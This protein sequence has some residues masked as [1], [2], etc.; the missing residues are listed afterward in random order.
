MNINKK[1]LDTDKYLRHVTDVDPSLIGEHL[2]P[3]YNHD[4]FGEDSDYYVFVTSFGTYSKALYF[5]RSKGVFLLTED[6]KSTLVI[7]KRYE[8]FLDSFNRKIYMYFLLNN[9]FRKT[10]SKEGIFVGEYVSK[11]KVPIIPD[12]VLSMDIDMVLNDDELGIAPRVFVCRDMDYYKKLRKRID[13]IKEY[14]DKINYIE[15][16]DYQYDNKTN[17][18]KVLK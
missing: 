7:I 16:L 18:I 1:Y 13:A 10:I 4:A 14:E 12:A 17:R 11:E 15:S 5:L 9:Q 8:N 3:H 2:I 6:E